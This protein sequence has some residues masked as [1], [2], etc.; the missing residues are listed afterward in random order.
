[1]TYKVS[2]TNDE[3]LWHE[4][5]LHSRVH[6]NDV[7]SLASDI[8]VPNSGIAGDEVWP[9]LDGEHVGSVLEHSAILRSVQSQSE[10]ISISTCTKEV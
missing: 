8:Q 5:I 10:T 1:M 3:S 9:W 4:V 7:A 6:L 2:L